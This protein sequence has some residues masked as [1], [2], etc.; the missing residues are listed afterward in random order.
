MSRAPRPRPRTPTRSRPRCSPSRRQES[1]GLMV[2]GIDLH[3]HSTASDGTLTP[4]GVVQEAAERGVA[5]LALTDH[6]TTSGLSE[7]LS[8]GHVLRVSVVPGVELSVETST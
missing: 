6:D 5:L 7:A 1:R 4:A 8:Q 3:L 2:G